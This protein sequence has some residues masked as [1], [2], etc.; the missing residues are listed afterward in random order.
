MGNSAHDGQAVEYRSA[1]AFTETVA[2]LRDTI[3]HSGLQIFAEIDHAGGAAKAGFHM[4]PSTLLIYG[5]P[6]GG[7][8]AMLAVPVAALD[9]PL[10]VLVRQRSDG[11]VVIAFHP[12][13]AMLRDD[14]V[15]RDIAARLSRA[16]E[17]LIDAIASK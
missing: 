17:I 8:P 7:T 14:G 15:P 6:A 9:L 10:R 11:T 1:L 2:R 16:Q 13:E 5:S 4:D 12:A 3:V